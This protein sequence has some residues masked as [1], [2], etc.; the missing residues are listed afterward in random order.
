MTGQLIYLV[1]HGETVWNREDRIQG[2]QD[3]PLTE[4]GVDQ[5]RRAGITLCDLVDRAGRFTLV[6]SPLGRA[7]RSAA[8]ILETVR[9]AVAEVRIDERLVEMD[10][11]RWEGL[12]RREIMARDAELWRRFEADSWTVAPPQ[13]ESYGML[14][15]RAKAW[16]ESMA[17]EPRLVVVGHGGFGRMLRGVYLGLPPRRALALKAPQDALHRLASGTIAEV[18]TLAPNDD[19]SRRE[20]VT[21]SR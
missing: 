21:P 16:L 8:L 7:R 15:A 11:G 10:W 18:P 13:G 4:R 2:R 14:A 3:A 17:D 5:A 9:P 19:R 20:T 6:T 1:R 12:L